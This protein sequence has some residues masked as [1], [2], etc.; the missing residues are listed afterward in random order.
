MNQKTKTPFVSLT[1]READKEYVRRRK[2]ADARKKAAGEKVYPM[3]PRLIK[4]LT[5]SDQ[6]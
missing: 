1:V 2:L 3:T 4:L 6:L 5:H